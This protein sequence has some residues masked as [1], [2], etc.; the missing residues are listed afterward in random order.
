MV[1]LRICNLIERSEPIECIV[2]NEGLGERKN[3]KL[4]LSRSGRRTHDV[5][6][7]P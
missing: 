2:Q 6:K 5:W 3:R 7:A 4:P 1:M